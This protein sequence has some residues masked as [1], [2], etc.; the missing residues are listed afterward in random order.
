MFCNG[1]AMNKPVR[2]SL[3]V[4]LSFVQSVL[5]VAVMAV[6]IQSLTMY[7]TRR[8]QKRIEQELSLQV[9][10]LVST[11]SSYHAALADNVSKLSA[12]FSTYFP[13]K[14]TVDTSKNVVI[15]D[16]QTPAITAGSTRLN[17]NTEIVDRFTAVTQAVGTVFVLSGDDFIR[18]S[19]S[20]KK[21][22]GSRAIGTA[23]ERTHPAYPGLLRGEEFV[24]KA[25]LFGKDYITKY[26]PVKDESGRVIAV[27]FIGLDFTNSLKALKEK[28]R[29]VKIGQTGYIYAIEAKEGKDAG[30]LQIHPAKEG[31]N[32]IDARDV[33]GREFVR[34][35]LKR[36]EGVIRYHWINKELGETVPR[37]KS[38]AYRYLKE[39]D[40]IIA[41]GASLEELGAEARFLRNAMIIAT[42]LVIVFLVLIFRFIVRSWI[43]RPLS[44]F[45][46]QIQDLAE[47]DSDRLQRLDG[48]RADELGLLAKSFNTLLDE[49]QRRQQQLKD[50]EENLRT[51]ADHTYDWEYWRNADGAF[52]YVSPSC[53]RITGYTAEE[54]K[55]DPGLLTRIVHPDDRDRYLRHLADI[56]NDN[57]INSDISDFR[58]RTRSGEECWIAHVCQEVFNGDGKSLGRRAC[59]RDVTTSKQAE[60]KL[61]AFSALM[62]QKNAELG[63]ALITAEQATQAKSTFLATMS[64]EIRTPMNGVIGMTGLLL[65]TELNKEQ[66]EF[67]EIV[68]MSGENLLSL[69]NDILDFSKI[70]AGKLDM[71]VLDFDLRTT[72]E[73]TATLLAVR[74]ANAGLELICRIDPDVPSYLKGDP[75]RLRQIITNL[76]GNSIKF[77]HKGEVSIGATLD[78]ESDGFAV[79]RFEIKDTGIG[80]PR[81]RQADIFNPF[82]QV[83]GSTTRKYGGT[84]LGLAIC[85]QLTELM[86]GEIGVESKEGSGTTVFFTARFEKQPPGAQPVFIPQADITGTKVLVVDDN[87]TNR[88]LMITLLNHWGCRYETAV[89]GEI[90]LALLQEAVEKNDPFRIVLLDQEMPGMDGM[91]VGRRIKA[92]P[93]LESTLMIMVTSLGHRGDASVLEQI[94]FAGYLNKPV[95]QSQLYDCMAL[96]LNLATLPSKANIP[97]Q[98]IITRHKAAE[99]ATRA[100]RILLAEDNIINQKVMQSMLSK[101]GYKADL[102]A[103]GLEALQ[104]LEMIDY[105]LVLMDCQMPEMNGFEAT[106]SIRDAG[107]KVLNHNVPV[108]AV[109]ANA[110]IGDC[111]LCIEAGMNDYLSKPVKKEE[112]DEV[113]EKWLKQIDKSNNPVQKPAEPSDV[114]MLFD[115]ADMLDRLDNDHAFVQMILEEML[116]ELPQQL[117]ELRELCLGGDATAIRLQAHTMKGLAAN[118]STAVLREICFE[119]EKAAKE[120]DVESARVLLPELERATLMT[121][122]AIRQ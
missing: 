37:E 108:I 32:Y 81:G 104:A 31:I 107:S 64:H 99:A 10:V 72:M 114:P 87:A 30:K 20:L 62:E 80:I 29:S 76:A 97:A 113:L 18:V 93:L 38:V 12:V 59:N 16:K 3:G 53:E 57:G 67:A 49:V 52:A 121:I 26:L 48:N 75:G 19:T 42:L 39:W 55:K 66:R 24:G 50:S 90:G 111:E 58:I 95:R 91:T 100:P 4:R 11:M 89:D 14:F 79:I 25:T 41:A 43:T 8:Q 86:G 51:V 106:S 47:P 74:A 109:T 6:F 120:G 60:E 2:F 68:R 33:D 44:T 46:T 92:D 56:D 122:E 116:L 98:S 40:W 13:G 63:A 65:E 84:G 115:R 103:N 73:D 34:E 28:I 119:I 102:V 5:I 112:L 7:I 54:F 110:M 22:D 88:M 101:L 78:S 96:V 69:I 1:D 77:T 35:M 45:T 118:V 9:V 117:Q 36:K 17:L 21:E 83:D 23:L 15:G 27:L 82:T 61:L 85:K 71:E 70:E 94:G 105:D